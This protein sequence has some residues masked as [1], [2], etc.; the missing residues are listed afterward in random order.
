MHTHTYI[1]THTHKP[2]HTN[3]HHLRWER[4]HKPRQ[5]RKEPVDLGSY[6]Y[7]EHQRLQMAGV[8]IA[9]LV[10]HHY[11]I[12]FTFGQDVC[13]EESRADCQEG[14]DTPMEP[15]QLTSFIRVQVR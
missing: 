3:T 15:L 10:P 14:E 12:S 8:S 1:E 7:K 2:I 6:L 13:Q 9:L 4:L 5:R 11:Q